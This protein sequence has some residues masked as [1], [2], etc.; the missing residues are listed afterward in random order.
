MLVLSRNGSKVDNIEYHRR[1]LVQI[2]R[3]MASDQ[4]SISC[5]PVHLHQQQRSIIIQTFFS[6]GQISRIILFTNKP[7]SDIDGLT[8]H[9]NNRVGLQGYKGKRLNHAV[10][11]GNVH[12]RPT[13]VT[14]LRLKETGVRLKLSR[15]SVIRFIFVQFNPYLCFRSRDV[16]VPRMHP[17][18]G[19]TS[20]H[21]DS[22]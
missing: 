5:H 11:D 12:L 20:S 6:L 19:R 18:V 1:Q 21:S 17:R 7:F 9:I 2:N 4:L 14:A 13:A 16:N 10:K 22:P 3:Q 15:C 8:G